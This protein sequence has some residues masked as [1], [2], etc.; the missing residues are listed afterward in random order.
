MHQTSPTS[1]YKQPTQPQ[2]YKNSLKQISSK[3]PH[4]II[5]QKSNIENSKLN[6]QQNNFNLTKIVS[7]Q[8]PVLIIMILEYKTLSAHPSLGTNCQNWH[9]TAG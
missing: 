2:I 3:D 4:N 7:N 5:S 8:Y 9:K 1:K 6:K